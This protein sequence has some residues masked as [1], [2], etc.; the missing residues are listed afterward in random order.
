MFIYLLI[1]FLI[2]KQCSRSFLEEIVARGKVGEDGAVESHR[3]DGDSDRSGGRTLQQVCVASLLLYIIIII[4]HYY[5]TL[6]L[7]NIICYCCYYYKVLLFIIIVYNWWIAF[8]SINSFDQLRLRLNWRDLARE[9]ILLLKYVNTLML[10]SWRR[11]NYFLLIIINQWSRLKL[12]TQTPG[13]ILSIIHFTNHRPFRDHRVQA[14][15][16]HQ[17]CSSSSSAIKTTQ[18]N[19]H[20][21]EPSITSP[22]PS[23]GSSSSSN[24]VT[25]KNQVDIN[26]KFVFVYIPVAI[27][28]VGMIGHWFMF[29]NHLNNLCQSFISSNSSAGISMLLSMDKT[30]ISGINIS[31]E[32]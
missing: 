31:S 17:R 1:V 6:L 24:G 20:P 23:V 15:P 9:I 10:S 13:N 16:V 19:H 7:Y 28:N 21:L 8:H 26:L 22:F 3:G 5:L 18:M 30:G 27:Y 14:P 2:F 25:F 4:H 12:L 29:S 32:Y 11:T